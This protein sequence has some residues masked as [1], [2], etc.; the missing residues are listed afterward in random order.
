[1]IKGENETM[2]KVIEKC[3]IFLQRYDIPHK[4]LEKVVSNHFSAKADLFGKLGLTQ[5]NRWMIYANTSGIAEYKQLAVNL[6]NLMENKLGVKKIDGVL[7][8]VMLGKNKVRVTSQLNKLLHLYIIAYNSGKNISDYDAFTDML[9]KANVYNKEPGKWLSIISCF[10][11]DYI[12][13]RNNICISGNPFDY[14]CM[15]ANEEKDYN[16]CTYT[17]CTRPAGEYFNTCLNY[18]ASDG[19]LIGFVKDNKKTEIKV[20]RSIIYANKNYF[21][22][23]RRFGAMFDDE[24]GAIAHSLKSTFGGNWQEHECEE[25]GNN[26]ITTDNCSYVDKHYGNVYKRKN[27]TAKIIEIVQGIC[28]K[29]GNPI[30][31]FP[32]GGQCRVCFEGLVLCPMCGGQHRDKDLVS[33]EGY[34]DRVCRSCYTKLTIRCDNCGER[35]SKLVN[36]SVMYFGYKQNWCTHCFQAGAAMCIMCKKSFGYVE[37]NGDNYICETCR[38]HNNG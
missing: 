12:K 22:V 5:D 3:R 2:E 25:V 29:C 17:S 38:G 14:L 16:Y 31:D 34:P 6:L 13:Q 4:H 35:M 30:S 27:S 18:L 26:V 10:Y 23:G 20:G 36:Q 33:V 7:D 19:V 28:L 1:M 15:S 37:E 11:G 32:K 21:S 9:S 24:V 8:Y